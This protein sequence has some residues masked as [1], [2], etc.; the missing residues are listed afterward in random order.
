MV[1]AFKKRVCLLKYIFLE[2]LK[3]LDLLQATPVFN[4]WR[5]KDQGSPNLSK[6]TCS[7]LRRI[8]CLKLSPCLGKWGFVVLKP[9]YPHPVI[10]PDSISFL[11]PKP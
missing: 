11:G 7:I 8:L 1:P 9:W 3:A 2:R 6:V 10:L 4:R 5:S